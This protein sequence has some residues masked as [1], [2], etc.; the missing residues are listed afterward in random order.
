MASIVEIKKNDT[1]YG[2]S[3]DE[4]VYIG[5]YNEKSEKIGS[6]FYL[7]DSQ[8]ISVIKYVNGFHINENFQSHHNDEY[9]NDY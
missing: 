8:I 1:V 7:K 5:Q 6:W 4:L 3:D 9:G 2:Y